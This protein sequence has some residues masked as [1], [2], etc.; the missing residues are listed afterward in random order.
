MLSL[1]PSVFTGSICGEALGSA[2]DSLYGGEMYGDVELSL[3]LGVS[4]TLGVRK[5]RALKILFMF[6]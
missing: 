2:L 5:N 6:P 1:T 4:G 3:T